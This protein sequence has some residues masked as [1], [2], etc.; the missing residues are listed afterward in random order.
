MLLLTDRIDEWLMSY[1]PEFDGKQFVDVA[2]GD[3]D[4]GSLDSEEDKKAQEEV[5]KSKEG[6]IERLK[7]V[8]DEQVSEVRVSTA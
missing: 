2:R 1:L 4:L 8:L 6:L 7:K 3:L 5:A